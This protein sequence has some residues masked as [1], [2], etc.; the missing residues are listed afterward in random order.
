MSATTRKPT[1]ADLTGAVR[2]A[3]QH[4]AS[5]DGLT[6]SERNSSAYYHLLGALSVF[7]VDVDAI[8][9]EVAAGVVA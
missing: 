7:G 8:R 3:E 9:A 5:L 6:Y 1:T 2:R 4:A